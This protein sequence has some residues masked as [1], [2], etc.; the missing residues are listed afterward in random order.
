[1]YHALIAYDRFIYLEIDCQKPSDLINYF[2]NIFMTA[3]LRKGSNCWKRDMQTLSK[4]QTFMLN[5]LRLNELQ[6]S[7]VFICCSISY[8]FNSLQIIVE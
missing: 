4:M 5:E 7:K 1:M 3:A 6:N 8:A 2:R